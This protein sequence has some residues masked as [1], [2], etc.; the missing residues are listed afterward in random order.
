MDAG[1]T[2]ATKLVASL[3]KRAAADQALV[4]AVSKGDAS[5]AIKAE[6]SRLEA[7]SREGAAAMNDLHVKQR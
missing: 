6:M 7:A 3:E 4:A 5:E 1:S 2:L